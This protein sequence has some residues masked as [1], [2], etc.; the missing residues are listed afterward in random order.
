MSA[1]LHNLPPVPLAS[2]PRPLRIRFRLM[3][4]TNGED[5]TLFDKLRA[6]F[7]AVPAGSVAVQ[8]RHPGLEGAALFRRAEQLRELTKKSAAPLLINDR[9]DVAVAV[10]AD[11]VHLPSHGLPVRPAR[12]TAGEDLL[13][14]AAAHGAPEARMAANGGADCVLYSPVFETPSKPGV[15]PIGTVALGELARD[16]APRGV[17]VFGLGGIDTPERATACLMVGARIACLRGVLA[18]A[19]PAAAARAFLR[20]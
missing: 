6:I 13:I 17:V 1:A 8:L 15:A 9:L 7:A 5:P 16:L 4:I 18:A 11:G 14:S 10:G 19:D 3:L 2:E 20:I 12:R